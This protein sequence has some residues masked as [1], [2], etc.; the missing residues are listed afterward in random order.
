M[1]GSSSTAGACAREMFD[2]PTMYLYTCTACGAEFMRDEKIRQNTLEKF[3]M[4]DR[5]KVI[6]YSLLIA[7][8]KPREKVSEAFSELTRSLWWS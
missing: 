4:D 2:L 7:Y 1:S 6:R 8:S 5:I 3:S